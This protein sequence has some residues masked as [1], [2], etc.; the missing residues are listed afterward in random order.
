M[1]Q[2]VDVYVKTLNYQW[3]FIPLSIAIYFDGRQFDPLL[4]GSLFPVPLHPLPELP[5]HHQ[6]HEQL[7]VGTPV[8]TE[9]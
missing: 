1:D 3:S 2:V 5:H 4:P 9:P 6:A 7:K 8:K